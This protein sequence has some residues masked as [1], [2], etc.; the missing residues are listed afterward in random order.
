MPTL[1][2]ID[3]CSITTKPKMNEFTFETLL[4]F[5]EENLCNRLF[6]YHLGEPANKVIKLRFEEKR[7]CHLLGFQHI[8]KGLKNA[9]DYVGQ[10][11]YD[12]LQKQEVTFDTFKDKG[13]KMKFKDKKNR[14]L[15]FPFVHQ[16][17]LNPTAII[18]S[19]E[20]LSTNIETEFFFY[21]L[22]DKCYLHLGVDSDGQNPYYFPKTFVERTNRDF[23]EGQITVPVLKVEILLD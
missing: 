20:N 3:L 22:Q 7:L 18:F 19:N 21:R 17:L 13:L 23:I 14:I 9:T 10:S 4:E 8:F 2:A 16:I 5:Y 11:G 1:T 15:Y 12:L 6:I